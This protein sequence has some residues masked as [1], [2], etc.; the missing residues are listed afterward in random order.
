MAQ[1]HQLH[2]LVAD[3]PGQPFDLLMRQSEKFFEEAK[4]VHQFKRRWM[5]RVAAEVAQE[6][7]VLLQYDCIDAGPSE[8]ETEHHPR[9]AAAGYTTLCSH[10]HARHRYPF[11]R[12]GRQAAAGAQAGCGVF[13][14]ATPSFRCRLVEDVVYWNTSRLSG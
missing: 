11:P 2:A 10:R 7:G 4:L 12:A 13:S 14:G 1:I 8:Q 3:L 5:N 6:I 9:G